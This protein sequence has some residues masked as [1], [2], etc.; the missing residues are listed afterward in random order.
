MLRA[1]RRARRRPR[2]RR[3]EGP[4]RLR[5]VARRARRASRP[6]TARSGRGRPGWHIECTAIALEHLGSDLRRPGR[7][8]RPGLPAPRDVRRPGP[9]RRARARRSRRPTRTPAWSATT[10]RRCRSRGA[11]WSSS[12]RCATA[13]S[14]RWR[15]GWRCCATTTAPTGSGPTTSCG[16]PSTTLG[17]WRRALVPGRRRPGRARSS[18]AVL[19]ALADDLDAPRA[20]AAVDAWVAATLGTDGLADTSDPDAARADRLRRLARRRPRRSSPAEVRLRPAQSSSSCA[21]LEVALELAG[22]RLAGA[23]G[24]SVVS[25]VSS[26]ART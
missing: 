26:S 10:A 7:R 4:A 9:G 2:P 17:R 16:T 21:A 14:T 3:Q 12:R 1:L 5:A 22:D 23:S 11:T 24:R 18:S 13:T 6:G 20:V 25:R 19:A 8:Q 15:S